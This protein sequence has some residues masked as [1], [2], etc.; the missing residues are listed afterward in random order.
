MKKFW[1]AG[2]ALLAA[3][4]FNGCAT[5]TEELFETD[6]PLAELEQRMRQAMDP[7]GRYARAKTTI[8][9]Q[10]V[11][12]EYWLDEPKVEMVEVKFEQPSNFRWVTFEDNAPRFGII[13]NGDKDWMIDYSSRRVLTVDPEKR[14]LIERLRT[15]TRI[16]DPGS[17]LSE[18]FPDI[19]VQLCR[20]GDGEFYKLTCRKSP[21]SD[22]F[23]LYVG[24]D[25]YLIRRFNGTFTVGSSRRKL[26]YDARMIR[27]GMYEGV[28]IPSE[29][30]IISN[31]ERQKSKI[32]FYQL[33][34]KID[35]SEF[36]PPV[37]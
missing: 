14:D 32:I 28:R 29:T 33:D 8:S 25:D 30:E 22:S 15:L 2:A 27:Y 3:V 9:R 21:E 19:K 13:T 35:P 7:D 4:L 37:F 6:L 18:I 26:D 17:R 34:A 31:G 1:F 16:A 5:A 36:R 20:T 12:T 23:N 10:V 11:T 24:R